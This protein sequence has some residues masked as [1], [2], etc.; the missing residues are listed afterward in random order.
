MIIYTV[1]Q[2]NGTVDSFNLDNT[3][4]KYYTTLARARDSFK[5]TREVT[6]LDIKNNT[7]GIFEHKSDNPF[8]KDI[9]IKLS[10]IIAE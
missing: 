1:E 2:V 7:S 3:E 8:I 9:I 6:K 5:F 4:V 10:I